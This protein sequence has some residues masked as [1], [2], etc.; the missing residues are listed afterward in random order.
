MA[1]VCYIC[2]DVIDY[3]NNKSTDIVRPCANEICTARVHRDCIKKQFMSGST[4]N[5]L[6]GN[7]QSPIVQN[8]EKKFNIKK[9]C[10]TYLKIIFTIIIII[11]GP[12][13]NILL[14]L[15]KTIVDWKK[16]GYGNTNMCDDYAIGTIFYVFPNSSLL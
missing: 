11:F 6:C 7:C 1:E 15:G 10:E 14:A 5:K 16:C 8:I 9:C 13:C 2:F 12:V 4:C 3:Q